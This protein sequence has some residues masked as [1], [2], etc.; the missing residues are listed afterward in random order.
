MLPLAVAILAAGAAGQEAARP[1]PEDEL[2][3][4]EAARSEAIRNGDMKLLDAIYSDDFTGVAGTGQLVTKKQ[5]FEIFARVDPTVRFT[6]S[7]TSA[8]VF[9]DAG[10][11]SGRLA[12][13]REDGTLVSEARFMHLFVRRDGRYRFVAG[14]ST[15]I[16]ASPDPFPGG[17]PAAPRQPARAFE[18]PYPPN[19]PGVTPPRKLHEVRPQWPAMTRPREATAA[20]DIV[21][22]RD[23]RVMVEQT[24]QATDPEWERACRQAVAQWRYEAASKD[25]MPVAVRLTVTCASNV[26]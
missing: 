20:L 1:S 23:G 11:V 15:P 21:I 22:R 4:T 19:A 12:G 13:R 17:L 25:G 2:L 24:R 6:T 9:G 18:E 3:R 16:V 10:V 5:L 26:R 8:R 14:Q 7:E